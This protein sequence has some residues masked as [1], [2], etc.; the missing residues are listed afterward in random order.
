MPSRGEWI[1]VAL[2]VLGCLCLIFDGKAE[3]IGIDSTKNTIFPALI[4][5]ISAFFGAIYFMSSARNVKK[6][7]MCLLLFIM[8]LNNFFLCSVI[9]KVQSGYTIE[10]FSTSATTGCLGFLSP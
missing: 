7:P 8:N 4:D 5:L 2:A 9:A 10:I 1:G 6:I 3:R